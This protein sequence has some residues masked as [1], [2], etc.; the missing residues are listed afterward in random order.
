MDWVDVRD[1]NNS[2]KTAP[3][4]MLDYSQKLVA[5]S[6]TYE[7]TTSL[8]SDWIRALITHLHLR[9]SISLTTEVESVPS[10][11]EKILCLL[12]HTRALV[13]PLKNSK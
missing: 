7:D 5:D 9:E 12:V 3:N 4:K 1:K 13:K 10:P 2:E 6:P 8:K 11:E